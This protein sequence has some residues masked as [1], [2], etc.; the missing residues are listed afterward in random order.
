MMLAIL[1]LAASFLP[2]KPQAADTQEDSVLKDWQRILEFNKWPNKGG[3]LRAGFPFATVDFPALRKLSQG[4]VSDQKTMSFDARD[5]TVTRN[6]RFKDSSGNP[7]LE[8]ELQVFPNSNDRA[9][10]ALLFKLMATQRGPIDTVYD[11]AEVI[12]VTVGDVAFVPSGLGTSD[13]STVGYVAFV[14]DNVRVLLTKMDGVDVDLADLAKKMD[15][16]IKLQQEVTKAQ[17]QKLAPQI[18]TFEP[19]DAIIKAFSSTVLSI[20]AI[21]PRN[22]SVESQFH[23]D[24]GAVDTDTSV[25]PARTMYFSNHQTGTATV[26]LSAIS[27]ALLVSEKTTTIKVTP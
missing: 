11:R 13:K 23:P 24:F 18:S 7:L 17:L 26:T 5:L 12:G 25:T 16:R 6:L 21:D 27:S 8:I 15:D 3:K 9:H 22:L 19:K 4:E 20:T 14:R 2:A 1:V 10:W